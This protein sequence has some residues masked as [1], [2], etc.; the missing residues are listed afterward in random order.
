[1]RIGVLSK[2]SDLTRLRHVFAIVFGP[3]IAANSIICAHIVALVLTPEK[4]AK[5]PPTVSRLLAD[6]SFAEPFALAM[7]ISAVLLAVAIAQVGFFLNNCI[8]IAGQDIARRKA[9]LH[10]AMAS[11]M[12]AV[13]GMI[14]L[15]QFTGSTNSRLHDVGSYMLFFGHAIGISLIGLLIRNLL[16][17][18]SHEVTAQLI[19]LRKF[20]VRAGRIAALSV[21]YG[22]VYFGGKALPEEVFFWQRAIMSILEIVLIL[23]F[24]GF[25]ISFTPFIGG[26][27]LNANVSACS[28]SPAT[29]AEV[30]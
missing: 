6:P 13:V 23:S 5:A 22:A 7:I 10:A 27:R 24:L 20:P 18:C 17:A 16:A 30:I 11:E 19:A 3:F 2:F 29:D 28:D 1:V 4:Y 12:I 25:L 14:V 8:K 15:S 9:L 21:V 26:Y